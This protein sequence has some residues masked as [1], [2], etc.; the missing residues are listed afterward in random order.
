MLVSKQAISWY[1]TVST[2]I[3]GYQPILCS[4]QPVINDIGRFL[5]VSAGIKWHLLRVGPVFSSS[6]HKRSPNRRTPACIPTSEPGPERPERDSHHGTSGR[7]RAKHSWAPAPALHAE[8]PRPLPIQSNGW[9]H[10]SS[11]VTHRRLPSHRVLLVHHDLAFAVG[12]LQVDGV[13]HVQLDGLLAPARRGRTSRV[14]TAAAPV[15]AADSGHAGASATAV[16]ELT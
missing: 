15:A 8:K 2:D 12:A 3:E 10:G 5:S 9:R 6:N 13:P 4:Y 16:P 14:E 11:S 1:Q 7:A